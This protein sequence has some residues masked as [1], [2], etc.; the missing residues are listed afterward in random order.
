MNL[1]ARRLI[2]YGAILLFGIA[3]PHLF[4][5]YLQQMASLWLFIVFALSWDVCGGQMGY[6]SFGNVFFLGLG[7]YACAVTQVS[8]SYEVAEYTSARGGSADFEFTAAEW[9]TG[10]FLGLPVGALLAVLSAVVFG[11]FILSIRG[12][13]FAI[14]TLGLGIAAGELA[15]GWDWI[16]AGS[17]MT[18]P[19]SPPALGDTNVLLYYLAFLLAVAA[20]L[21]F[22]WLYTTRFGLAIN[23]IRDGE[24]KAEA[25][26]LRTTRIKVTAWAFAALFLGIAG[27]IFGNL[28]TFIDPIDV[29]FS[30]ATFGVWMVLMAILGGKGT[31]WG[32]VIGAVIFQVMKELFWTYLLGW[33]MVAL[34]LLIVLIVVFFPTGILGYL[35]ERFPE[36][37]GRG[38]DESHLM[39]KGAG[40]TR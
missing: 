11:M 38:A 35:R 6:N 5:A 8:V 40:E 28:K 7:M 16:G 3:G 14:C 33:Q 1:T 4:P 25:M 15:A 27:G 17:G 30:G 29:A 36:R 9:L 21:F 2:L 34:G 24:E 20:F 10:L 18:T 26:G 19:M 23:A 13:Y 32:P 12:H 31:L 37:F 39:G 22:R